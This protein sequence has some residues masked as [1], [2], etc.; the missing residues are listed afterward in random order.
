MALDVFLLMSFDLGCQ[1]LVE[2]L[3]KDVLATEGG[4]LR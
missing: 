2:S 4:F 1:G 3:D